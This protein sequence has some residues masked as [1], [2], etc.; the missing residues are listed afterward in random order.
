MLVLGG[1]VVVSWIVMLVLRVPASIAFL[2]L[3]IGQLLVSQA[4]PDVFSFVSSS[5]NISDV[6]YVQMAMLLLPLLLTVLILRARVPASKLLF[7][8]VPMLLVVALA[9]FLLAPLLFP[10]EN[11]LNTATDGRANSYQSMVAAG[12]S[13]AGL[14]SA[15][16][17]YPK[18]ANGKHR[19]YHK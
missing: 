10:L 8:A 12:A 4:G 2:S 15:W 13:V 5:A 17:S 3:L 1:I 16:L 14:V 19:K 9:V 18:P 7:E 11:L 6:R